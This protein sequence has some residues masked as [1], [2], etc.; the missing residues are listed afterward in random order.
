ME[1]HSVLTV[2]YPTD[3]LAQHIE[4]ITHQELQLLQGH[5]P[6]DVSKLDNIVATSELFKH[7][8]LDATLVLH[9][10]EQKIDN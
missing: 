9:A 6:P 10:T 3:L 4:P 1:G 2:T 8:N 5:S 7:R